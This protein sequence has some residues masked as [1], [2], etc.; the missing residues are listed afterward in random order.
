MAFKVRFTAGLTTHACAN[1]VPR[2]T[3]ALDL[4]RLLD[5]KGSREKMDYVYIN[6][7]SLPR[8]ERSRS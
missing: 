3:P 1:S 5:G 6:D 4:A 2:W 7:P 8:H